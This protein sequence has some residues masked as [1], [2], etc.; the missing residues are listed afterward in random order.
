[1]YFNADKVDHGSRVGHGNSSPAPFS[2]ST[3]RIRKHIQLQIPPQ[4]S[5]D[6][7]ISTLARYE[8]EVNIYSALLAKN[9]SESGWFDLEL[10]GT[11]ERIQQAIDYL[12]S[13]HVEIWSVNTAAKESWGYR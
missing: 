8:V 6:P 1:M 3:H 9:S 11:A 10:R 13:L 5:Q 2:E 7:I 12:S 4:Y